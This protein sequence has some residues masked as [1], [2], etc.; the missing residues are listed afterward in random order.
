M[1]IKDNRFKVMVAQFHFIVDLDENY[2]TRNVLCELLGDTS[3]NYP[4][5]QAVR[6]QLDDLYGASL[7]TYTRIIGNKHDVEFQITGIVDKYTMQQEK[8]VEPMLQFLQELIFK[9]A[10]WTGKQ[11][12]EIK[13]RCKNRILR[14]KEDIGSTSMREALKL[15]GK[16]TLLALD[17]LG[18][19][20]E[21]ERFTLD[22]MQEAYK[23]ML[24]SD[25][26]R[27]YLVGDVETNEEIVSSGVL[28]PSSFTISNNV[29]DA[30]TITK[31]SDQSFVNIVV[32]TNTLQSEDMFFVQEVANRILGG[33]DS[34]LFRNVREKEGLAYSIFSQLYHFDGVI[35]IHG[36]VEKAKI[37]QCIDSVKKEIQT[38]QTGQ[39][40]QELLEKVKKNLI[41]QL[42]RTNDSQYDILARGFMREMRD[43]KLPF[44]KQTEMIE[45]ITIN[46]IV[47]LTRKWNIILEYCVEGEKYGEN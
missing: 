26:R 19:I 8:N 12:E 16:N 37:S 11:L 33:S 24:A 6:K 42:K 5:K 15:A 43:F 41:L 2:V 40:T 46:D 1:I 21:I 3:F 13:M 17:P 32:N 28:S 39:F 34:L 30:K 23:K 18:N 10:N 7:K 44:A 45:A 9:P 20:D 36:G 14:E 27:F 47:E 4:T 22:D 35:L 25:V 31:I 29:F 38:L